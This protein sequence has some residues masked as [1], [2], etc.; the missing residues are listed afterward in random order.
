MI[1]LYLVL[2]IGVD[3]IFI[4]CNSY[5]LA[6]RE[7]RDVHAAAGGGGGSGDDDG[8]PTERRRWCGR[9]GPMADRPTRSHE[10]RVLASAL[11]HAVGVTALS[12]STTAV[13]FGASIASPITTIR[14]FSIFQTSVVVA[15]FVLILCL[16]LPL[17][18]GCRR[19]LFAVHATHTP[20]P[21][22]W[23]CRWVARVGVRLLLLPV[24]VL[25]APA[26]PPFWRLAGKDPETSI[27]PPL[28]WAGLLAFS[29]EAALRIAPTRSPP[30]IFGPDANGYRWLHLRRYAFAGGAAA[31]ADAAAASGRIDLS[32]I[33]LSGGGGQSEFE[34]WLT[35]E[36]GRRCL[37]DCDFKLLADGVCDA[38]CRREDCAWDG[39]DCDAAAAAASAARC[40]GRQRWRQ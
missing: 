1:S 13:A 38:P 8:P 20:P 14:Q 24:W 23:S 4:F 37:E 34:R 2:G 17:L 6:E 33:D 39:G 35:S 9:C 30:T 11:R 19:R 25:L 36:A 32:E 29:A 21:R 15:D 10:E 12:T 3:A 27:P 31:L 26:R 18:V 5:A 28:A 16:W 7:A 40:F 22:R